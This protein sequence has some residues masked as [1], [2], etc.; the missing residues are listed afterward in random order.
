MQRIQLNS[1]DG[2]ASGWIGVGDARNVPERVHANAPRGVRSAEYSDDSTSHESSSKR[3]GW[4]R[5]SFSF[6]RNAAI[7]LAL[8]M[9]VPFATI[10]VAGGGFQ[11]YV[12]M[13]ERLQTMLAKTER[14]RAFKAPVDASISADDAGLAFRNLQ[15][16]KRDDD[17]PMRTPEHVHARPWKTQ[18]LTSDLFPNGR[19]PSAP[20]LLYTNQI[21]YNASSAMS[22][23]ELAYLRNIAEA[24]IWSDFDRVAL[25]DEV[26]LIGGQYQLPFS[27]KAFAPALRIMNYAE[28][29]EMA[30]AAVARAAYYVALRDLDRAESTLKSVVSFGFVLMD[31]ATSAFDA[32]LGRTVAKTGADGLMQLYTI[33][34]KEDLAAAV[35]VP[36]EFPRNEAESVNRRVD[37]D[38]LHARLLAEANNPELPRGVR[39]EA[40]RS[41]SFT[42]CSNVR[43]VFMGPNQDVRD[44]FQNAKASLARFPGE[45]A[46]MDLLFELSERVPHNAGIKLGPERFIVGAA[47]IAGTVLNNPRV[48]AC[49]RMAMLSY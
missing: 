23:E 35:R 12:P 45:R 17:F 24:P 11:R 34:L 22:A 43:D 32:M 30:N 8:L 9:T 42:S 37:S 1:K 36:K 29:R 18:R 21:L 10:A 38:E 39:L 49:T 28:T 5:A 31:N 20:T 40:L 14:L 13:S 15:T 3:T 7:G 33:L 41:L 48:E 47:A 25:A 4:L 27:S 26:D 6:A 46:Y 19:S 2:L 44:A 16:Q